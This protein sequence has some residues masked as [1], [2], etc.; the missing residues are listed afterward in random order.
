MKKSVKVVDLDSLVCSNRLGLPRLALLHVVLLCFCA[1]CA[2]QFDSAIR[3]NACRSFTD[4]LL[5]KVKKLSQLPV[6][7]NWYE[8]IDMPLNS[9]ACVKAAECLK[10]EPSIM[11][12]LREFEDSPRRS[13]LSEC[14]GYLLELLKLLGSSS[15]IKLRIARSLSCLSV[16]MLIA[17]DADYVAELLQDLCSCLHDAGYLGGVDHES[18]VNE[19]KS[20]V[21]DLRRLPVDHT[22]ITDVFFFQNCVHSFV[23]QSKFVPNDLLTVECLEE[24]K[25]FFTCGSSVLVPS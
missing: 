9:W 7:D 2:K 15:I 1:N 6:I 25:L 8:Y 24:L 11:K 14:H 22:Q 13:F 21:V 5:S 3:D 23:L 19:F 16:D 18:A 20:L 10:S 4:C 12:A 17:G